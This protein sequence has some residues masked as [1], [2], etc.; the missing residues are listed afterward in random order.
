MRRQLL[1]LLSI[2]A[3]ILSGGCA[4]VQSPAS[5]QETKTDIL[6][7]SPLNQ[8]DPQS[9]VP[10]EINIS[11]NDNSKEETR[12]IVKGMVDSALKEF[13][14]IN[15]KGRLSFQKDIEKL[16]ATYREHLRDF[17]NLIILI[18]TLLGTILAIFSF[19]GVKK[20][21]S[22]HTQ[23][24]ETKNLFDIME[25]S[26][27]EKEKEL[28]SKFDEI[29]GKK[30]KEYT[31]IDKANFLDY[32]HKLY[33]AQAYLPL[34]RKTQDYKLTLL[35]LGEYWL[36]QK[37][38]GRALLRFQ[39]IER[40]QN[41]LD[42]KKNYVFRIL[43]S[44]GQKTIFQERILGKK[45]AKYFNLYG[46]AYVD[47]AKE[48]KDNKEKEEEF[49]SKAIDHYKKAIEIDK[50]YA[51]PYYN[52]GRVYGYHM[53]KEKEALE[54]YK[55]A[56]GKIPDLAK[57]TYRNMACSLIRDDAPLQD[58][59]K[60]LDNIPEGDP[61]WQEVIDDEFINPKIKATRE[62]SSFILKKFPLAKNL[63]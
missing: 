10:P 37:Q 44:L 25:N 22:I 3:I 57:E 12:M 32:E 54:W 23:L 8:L 15:L 19:F 34:N 18:I 31:S 24:T 58:I 33:F 46:C 51:S 42:S 56:F 59:I 50:N 49:L 55:Q 36:E 52:L 2:A 61:Y 1:I 9:V 14:N 60:T 45:T 39:E 29:I 13:E 38:A 48:C 20:Y 5:K 47:C 7:K 11:K 4:S 43:I 26:I 53:R 41:D 30:R 40:L 21:L 28:H 63:T 27:S 17:I 16:D 35:I 62:L 6:S